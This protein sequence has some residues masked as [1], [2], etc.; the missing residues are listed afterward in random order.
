MKILTFVEDK[1]YLE[2]NYFIPS[3][4][5]LITSAIG[6]MG[7]RCSAVTGANTVIIV[8]A[9]GNI[10]FLSI[11]AINGDVIRAFIEL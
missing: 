9:K 7:H 10:L 6:N 1:P 3:F 4:H 2:G 8:V 5:S 11:I